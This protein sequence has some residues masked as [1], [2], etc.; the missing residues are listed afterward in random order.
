MSEQAPDPKRMT[1]ERA[2][3]LIEIFELGYYAEQRSI[4]E[5]FGVKFNKDGTIDPEE[6]E[7]DELAE[8]GSLENLTERLSQLATALAAEQ[9]FYRRYVTG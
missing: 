5:T 7:L 2:Q 8:P 4:E 6:V 9:I 3:A 1:K